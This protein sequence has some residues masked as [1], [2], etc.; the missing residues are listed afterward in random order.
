MFLVIKV[1]PNIYIPR[2]YKTT[3][4]L[5]ILLCIAGEKEENL[6]AKPH[7][8]KIFNTDE[9]QISHRKFNPIPPR[10]DLNHIINSKRSDEDV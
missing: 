9:P 7:S 5:A 1:V 4:I 6:L 2:L 10:R 8:M 3:H